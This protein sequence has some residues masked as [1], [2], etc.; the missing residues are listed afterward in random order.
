MSEVRLTFADA[1]AYVLLYTCSYDGKWNEDETK[2][3]IDILIELMVAFDADQDGDGDVDAEDVQKSWDAACELFDGAEPGSSDRS[4]YMV[5]CLKFI[6]GC[7]G[8]DNRKVFVNRLQSLV[9]ADGVLHSS[10]EH[11]MKVVNELMA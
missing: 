2:R 1:V 9:E 3:A 6:K 8:A 7:L 5:G 10:E 11:L 4:E